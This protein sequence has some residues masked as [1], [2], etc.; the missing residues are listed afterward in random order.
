MAGLSGT[1]TSLTQFHH[2]LHRRFISVTLRAGFAINRLHPRSCSWDGRQVGVAAALGGG[3]QQN[4]PEL[5][6]APGARQQREGD[7]TFTVRTCCRPPV[8]INLPGRA[9]RGRSCGPIANF[10]GG[11]RLIG[12]TSGARVF[13]SWPSRPRRRRWRCA[14]RDPFASSSEA[15]KRKSSKITKPRCRN[16]HA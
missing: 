10:W 9:Q 13:C 12:C 16:R 7:D 11:S 8:W 14:S 5:R 15:R 1:L 2:L 3:G 4:A 6:E